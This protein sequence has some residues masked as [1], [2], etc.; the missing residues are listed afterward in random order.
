[1]KNLRIDDKKVTDGLLGRLSGL[2]IAA[3]ES[4]ERKAPNNGFLKDCDNLVVKRD[5]QI[6]DGVMA[7]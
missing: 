1:M 2:K 7:G 6:A 5:D 3:N 4:R